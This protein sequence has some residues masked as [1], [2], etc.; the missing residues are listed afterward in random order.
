MA[1]NKTAVV[2]LGGNAITVPGQ[3]DTIANQFANTR[4]SLGGIVELARRGFNLVVSHGNGPQVGNALLRIELARGKAPI[5]PLG[6][7]VADTEGGMGYMIEQS[8]QN[9]LRAEK[10]DR[11]VVTIIT[12]MIVDENDPAIENP[13]KFIGQFYSEAE[14]ADFTQS[15]GW[16]MKKDGS[17]GWRRVVPSPIPLKAVAAPTIRQLVTR[18][19]IVIACGGGG[20]PVY[21]D[22]DG[23]Y[24]G[25]DAVIDKDLGSAVIAGEIGADILSIL[26]SVDKVAINFGQ[27]NQTDLDTVTV[28][29]IKRYYD[30]GHFPPGSMGP[31]ILAATRFLEGGGKMVIITSFANAGKA[32]DGAVGTRIVPD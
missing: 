30:E 20:I 22:R 18:G 26:T 6:V 14:V 4:R 31:K 23:N 29:Q 27:P 2:A 19:V 15:R 11:A 7:L 5:L 17:R 10:I 32:L 1:G 24:E 3:E 16:Q 8:L 21:I 12:Q 9:R 28:S 25:I 13:T